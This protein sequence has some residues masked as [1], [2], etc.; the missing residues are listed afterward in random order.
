ME[1]AFAWFL[2]SVVMG[3]LEEEGL[4]KRQSQVV[5]PE[6][7]RKTNSSSFAIRRQQSTVR[8]ADRPVKLFSDFGL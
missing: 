1:V 7:H 4:H 6:W 8:L 2:E 5:A 3:H